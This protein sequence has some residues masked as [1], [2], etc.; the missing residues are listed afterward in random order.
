MLKQFLLNIKNN[1]LLI[2]FIFFTSV[3]AL[4]AG[5]DNS[6]IS[7]LITSPYYGAIVTAFF[8]LIYKFFSLCINI[9]HR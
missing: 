3:F 5:E 4:A 8:Y 6:L 2:P 9:I 1:K 7:I